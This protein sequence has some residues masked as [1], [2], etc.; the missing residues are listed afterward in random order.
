MRRGKGR[1]HVR[2]R[3]CQRV[4]SFEVLR[5]GLLCDDWIPP[6]SVPGYKDSYYNSTENPAEATPV[7]VSGSGQTLQDQYINPG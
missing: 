6:F 2:R 3:G 4:E 7:V 1:A 5:V